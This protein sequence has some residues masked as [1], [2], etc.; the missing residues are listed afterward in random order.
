M[1]FE[2]LEDR[3]MFNADVPFEGPYDIRTGSQF[4]ALFDVDEDGIAEI[5]LYDDLFLSEDGKL[6]NRSDIQYVP[7]IQDNQLNPDLADRQINREDTLPLSDAAIQKF[8]TALADDSQDWLIVRGHADVDGD[9]INEL[10][11]PAGTVG[12]Y[13]WVSNQHDRTNLIGDFAEHPIDFAEH[14]SLDAIAQAYSAGDVTGDGLDDLIF[15]APLGCCAGVGYVYWYTADPEFLPEGASM[16]AWY[17]RDGGVWYEDPSTDDFFDFNGD[18]MEDHV[19][20]H[21]WDDWRLLIASPPQLQA[22]FDANG[23]VD[24]Q[25]FLILSANFGAG[26]LGSETPRSTGDA[27]QDGR[28]NFADFLILSSEFGRSAVASH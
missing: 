20:M 12:E 9:G 17:V 19:V 10:I 18:G 11:A 28:V 25:D 2:L 7:V 13:I 24:F 26:E 21:D 16:G 27:N 15:K 5:L 8:E 1:R 14:P 23:V 22:D 6:E 3:Q 4:V